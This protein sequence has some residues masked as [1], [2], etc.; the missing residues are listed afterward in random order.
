MW[1]CF[2]SFLHLV[3]AISPC[4]HA[5]VLSGYLE[6]LLSCHVV[7]YSNTICQLCH[8]L[9]NRFTIVPR[10][11]LV[12]HRATCFSR[13]L[14]GAPTCHLVF[15][16]GIWQSFVPPGAPPCNLV[17]HQVI[18]CFNV[19][20]WYLMRNVPVS[21][22]LETSSSLC[23]IWQLV[24]ANIIAMSPEDWAHRVISPPRLDKLD[25]FN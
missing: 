20:L 5:S 14:P 1:S 7:R 9:R 13:N 2:K 12:S 3:T 11:H 24:I 22:W 19:P 25:S 17:I 21:P 6:T 15:Y 23:A 4:H 16:C 18:M 8:L 10:C